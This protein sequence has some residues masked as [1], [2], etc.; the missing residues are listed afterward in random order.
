[1]HVVSSFAP[2]PTTTPPCVH[3]Q[4]TTE[5]LPNS[6]P[7]IIS[8]NVRGRKRHIRELVGDGQTLDSCR[9]LNVSHALPALHVPHAHYLLA[10]QLWGFGANGGL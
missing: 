1:M 4:P 10:D 2:T 5:K 6:L 7:S 3:T 9:E 8:L